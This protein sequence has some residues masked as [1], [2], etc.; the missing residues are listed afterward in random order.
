MD[1]RIKTLYKNALNMKDRRML[2]E[3]KNEVVFI[4]NQLGIIKLEYESY[5]TIY[6][7]DCEEMLT[8]L[9][10]ENDFSVIEYYNPYKEN[11]ETEITKEGAEGL[12]VNFMDNYTIEVDRENLFDSISGM[13]K[14]IAEFQNKIIENKMTLLKMNEKTYKPIWEE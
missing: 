13:E 2:I 5:N 7:K 6:K 10:T 12:I 11:H 14:K 8:I 4:S 1:K 9:I 3:T